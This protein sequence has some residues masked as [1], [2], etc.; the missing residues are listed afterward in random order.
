MVKRKHT[1]SVLV[2]VII[3]TL[4]ACDI[5]NFHMHV[6]DEWSILEAAACVDDGLEIRSCSCGYEETRVIEKT[7][8]HKFV[9]G[10]CTYCKSPAS[11]VRTY[12]YNTYFIDSP[13][14]MNPHTYSVNTAKDISQYTTSTLYA[15]DYNESG[16]GFVIAPE[17]AAA[18]PIDVTAQYVGDEWSIDESDSARAWLISLR[19]DLKW[20]DGSAITA[21]DFSES[22]KRLLDSGAN[23]S[24]AK[25]LYSSKL[26]IANAKAYHDSGTTAMLPANKAYDSYSDDLDDK[27]IF[28][29]GAG[30][31]ESYIRTAVGFP[32][33][34]DVKKTADYLIQSYGRYMPEFTTEAAI[35]MEGK[36]LKEIKSD[37]N[38]EKAW[39]SALKFAYKFNL[40]EL[41]FCITLKHYPTVTFD[42]VG[43]K[44]LSNTELVIILENSLDGFD[45]N[46]SLISTLGLVH[47]ATYDTCVSTDENGN[48]VN[49]YGTSKDTYMSFGPYKLSEYSIDD[50]IVLEKNKKWFGYSDST[51]TGQY[52]TTGI[53]FTKYESKDAAL[54]AFIRGEID[55]VDLPYQNGNDYLDSDRAYYVNST[56]TFFIAMNPNLDA[57]SK[58]E[59]KNPG[60]NKSIMTVTEFRMAL[61]YALDREGFIKA[62]DPFSTPAFS[63]FNNV[64]CADPESGTMYRNTEA[65]KDA[66][67]EAWGINSNDIGEGLLYP[68]KDYAI[69]DITTGAD[70]KAKELFNEA[71]DKAVEAGIYNGTDTILITIGMPTSVAKYYRNGYEFLVNNFTEAVK[72]TKLEEKLTFNSDSTLSSSFTPPLTANVVDLLFGV[73]WSASAL[74]PY[75]VI[76]SY[77]EKGYQY[78]PS[79][80]DTSKTMM[81]FDINGVTYEASVLDWTYAIEGDTVQIQNTKTGEYIDYSCGKNNNDPDER[82]RLLAA[83]E[84]IILKNYNMIPINNSA[85]VFMLGYQV[86]YGSNKYVYGIGYGGVRYM[87]YDYSDAEWNDF[88]KDVNL[89]LRYK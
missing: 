79:F 14:S 74:N 55:Y 11:Y 60:Y 71:Y 45:L 52:Q 20:E 39:N 3:M 2:L 41:S 83:L 57:F 35:A 66:L 33:S 82:I 38:L 48:Y 40:N 9:N 50:V 53:V 30:E 5:G 84:C 67:L 89:S 54:E 70:I 72:G 1:I 4:T 8:K 64:I 15:Y 42:Q 68:T 37:P 85:S 16:D 28:S 88:V 75:G 44:A 34:Y 27:L 77:T 78:D 51:Y 47:I 6:F 25:S 61:S 63:I 86:D 81:Q 23:N 7:G 24:N 26:V 73:G 65:A 19:G 58:W 10:Y 76:G 32:S 43:I 69:S 13:D 21:Y 49:T 22:A 12:T 62:V 46:S 87:K 36:T 18:M 80:W 31:A 29:I 17:M 56:N 59:E